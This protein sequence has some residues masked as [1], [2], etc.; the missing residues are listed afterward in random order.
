MPGI[1]FTNVNDGLR[2]REPGDSA[3]RTYAGSDGLLGATAGVGVAN[4]TGAIG[5]SLIAR[6]LLASIG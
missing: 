1:S 2:T 3:A 4:D 5:A 6:D